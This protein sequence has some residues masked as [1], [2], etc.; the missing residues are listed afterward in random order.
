MIADTFQNLISVFV[1]LGMILWRFPGPV[2]KVLWVVSILLTVLATW[3]IVYRKQSR[4]LVI[5]L[6]REKAV[7]RAEYKR[8]RLAW[9]DRVSRDA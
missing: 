9:E 5:T 6:Q 4:D 1:D 3:G 8:D 7:E 2:D